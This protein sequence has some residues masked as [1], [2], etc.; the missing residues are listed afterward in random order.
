MNVKIVEFRNGR[1]FTVVVEDN[2]CYHS[3]QFEW[4]KK[5]ECYLY[6]DGSSGS[7]TWT[8]TEDE[9]WVAPD[10]RFDFYP[11]REYIKREQF[12]TTSLFSGYNNIECDSMEYCSQCDDWTHCEPPCAHIHWSDELGW[13]V[14]VTYCCD[15]LLKDPYVDFNVDTKKVEGFGVDDKCP[16][17][18]GLP[19]FKEV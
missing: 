8:I 12:D 10:A 1:P 11:G 13:W 6:Y 15:E 5:S 19:T 2:D 7:K 18:S 9:Y 16:H 3:Y 4:S 17:C 14:E